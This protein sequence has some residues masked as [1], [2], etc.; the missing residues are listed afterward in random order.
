[1]QKII[2]LAD[3][4]G[5]MPATIAM[6]KEIERLQVDDIWFLG[7]AVGKGPESDKTCDWVRSHCKHFIAGN[8]DH[9]L[10]ESNKEKL[11]HYFKFYWDQIGDE[12]FS[13]LEC[14]PQEASVW[15]S[16]IHFRLIHG[17]PIDQLYFGFDSEE[18]L[19]AGFRA[20]NGGQTYSGLICADSHMPFVRSIGIGYAINTG[21]VGNSIGVPK[22]HALLIEGELGSQVP[23]PVR[24]TILSVPYDNKKAA[25]IAEDY[26]QMPNMKE[27]QKEVMTGIYARL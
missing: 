5:N 20:A 6:E 25:E 10:C 7:D 24:M 26:T 12:R 18:K 23:A 16:G 27:Y 22:A 17:R 14:L 11:L 8:W 3:L 21:S 9:G 2:F 15:I 19:S 4:H 1:M 13:W